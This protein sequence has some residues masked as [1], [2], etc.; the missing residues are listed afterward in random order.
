M[1]TDLP[2]PEAVLNRLGKV[3]WSETAD[4][5]I[6]ETELGATL[7]L[8][9]N[10]D[11]DIGA[12]IHIDEITVPEGL[13]GSGRATKAMLTLCRLADEYHFVLKGGPV[14]WSDDP[15]GER[16]A[17]WVGLLGFEPDPSPP[18]LVHDRT[19]FYARRLPRPFQQGVRRL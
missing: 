11:D 3:R 17:A 19:A 5:F 8:C 13:R 16:F 6:V 12:G 9:P 14:G 15:W 10:S 1:D 2:K 7:Q 4:A 18:T